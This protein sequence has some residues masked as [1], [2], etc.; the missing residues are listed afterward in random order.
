MEGAILDGTI[1]CGTTMPDGSINNAGCLDK[2]RKE[3]E[4]QECDINS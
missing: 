1:F 3:N 4:C 2:L